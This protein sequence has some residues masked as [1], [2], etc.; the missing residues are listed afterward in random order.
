M[1]QINNTIPYCATRAYWLGYLISNRLGYI[2]VFSKTDSAKCGKRGLNES[3]TH[4]AY[5]NCIGLSRWQV[6]QIC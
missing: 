5:S 3:Q 1:E 6:L 4:Q 2:D